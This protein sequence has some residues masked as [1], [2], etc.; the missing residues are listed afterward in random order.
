MKRCSI[1][2]PSNP[3]PWRVPPAVGTLCAILLWCLPASAQAPYPQAQMGG[4]I[5]DFQ[6]HALIFSV[7]LVG[8]PFRFIYR[9]NAAAPKWRWSVYHAY[10]PVAKTLSLGD[11][12]SRPATP[13]P[14]WLSAGEVGLVARDGSEVY[15]FNQKG[16]HLR[17]LDALTGTLIYR[18][19]R[20]AAGALTAIEDGYGS[21]TRIERD[22]KGFVTAVVAPSGQRT[23]FSNDANGYP[24]RIT[25]PAGQ[26]TSL[27]YSGD[28]Q[29][30]ALT[31][32]RGSGY[33]FATDE[34]GHV[35]KLE[36]PA[37]S[38]VN[39]A[40]VSTGNGAKAS[41]NTTT[42]RESGWLAERRSDNETSVVMADSG[43]TEI[44]LETHTDGSTRIAY[45]DGRTL[46]WT[47]QPDP[48]WGP[49]APLLKTASFTTP[50]GLS[51]SLSLNRGVTLAD[52]G[53]PLSVTTVA[54]TARFNG[55]SYIRT[56]DAKSKQ[57]TQLT[58]AGR[59]SITTLDGHGRVMKVEVPGL[60]PIGLTYDGQGRLATFTQGT[61]AEARTRGVLYNGQG[62]V[63]SVTDPLKR[64]IRFEYDSAGR[65]SK[66]ILPD[67]RQISY[68][69]DA[70]GNR[71]SITPPGRPAHSFGYTPV[72]LVETY[73]P[74]RIE[75][76]VETSGSTNNRWSAIKAYWV[77]LW[78]GLQGL[79]HRTKAAPSP[80]VEQS[81]GATSYGYNSDGQVTKILR[82]NRPV[83]GAGV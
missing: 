28:G 21:S 71:I 8:T 45:P 46:N 72:N 31:D 60:L 7:P 76:G 41:W 65:V 4:P 18:F 38:S 37:G 68:S 57:I 26:T 27:T 10:D 52:A 75:Q 13:V 39:L 48:R 23:S 51:A 77:K 58:P 22:G 53:D 6:G 44:R 62:W 19:T 49:G 25:N 66:Q 83:T 11:G 42:G 63:A 32:P 17:T 24:T 40:L 78:S 81:P 35:T 36:D 16:E 12:R 14:S 70:N 5:I 34:S 82:P 59:R 54:D 9:S 1:L 29:L 73:L 47:Q 50:G 55:R 56:F 43:G 2:R 30:V 20:D 3:G 33:R 79:F 67:G 69:Y 74:P 15:V 64:S 61:G 80:L